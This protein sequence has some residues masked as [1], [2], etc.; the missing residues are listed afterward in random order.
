MSTISFRNRLLGNG[1]YALLQVT[2]RTAKYQVEGHEYIESSFGLQRP[3]IWVAWHG[4]TMMLASYFLQEYRPDSLIIMMPDDWRGETL[5]HWVNKIGATPWRMNLKGDLSMGAAR[6]VAEMLRMLR[7]GRNA[8]I[9]PDGPDGP[10]YQVKPGVAYLAQKSGATLLPIGAYTRSGYRLN[11]WDRYVVPWPYS[12]ISVVVG[13][14][15]H[16]NGQEE[17]AEV[18]ERLTDTLHRVSAQAGANYYERTR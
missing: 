4:M 18:T 11:R 17:L 15:V 1:L 2:K 13:E 12:R 8:Y 7:Q 9:T 16:L 10:A 3:V 6:K 5:A 14:P